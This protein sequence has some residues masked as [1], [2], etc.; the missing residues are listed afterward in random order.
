MNQRTPMRKPR[1][2]TVAPEASNFLPLHYAR[3]STESECVTCGHEPV[4]RRDD[5][6][7]QA[8]A[9]PPVINEILGSPGRPREPHLGHDFSRVRVQSDASAAASA[10]A[11]NATAYAVGGDVVFPS[12][13]CASATPEGEQPVAHEL[14]YSIPQWSAG[15]GVHTSSVGGHTAT[16]AAEREAEAAASHVIASAEPRM[17]REL[18]EPLA[19]ARANRFRSLQRAEDPAGEPGARTGSP[20]SAERKGVVMVGEPLTRATV[21]RPSPVTRSS[22]TVATGRRATSPLVPPGRGAVLP[23][24]TRADF[25]AR[26]GHNFEDVRVYADDRAARLAATQGANAFTVGSDIVFGTGQFAPHK[27]AGRNLLAHELTHVVQYEVA[28]AAGRTLSGRSRPGQAAEHQAESAAALAHGG[29]LN[30]LSFQPA[31]AEVH[32]QDVVAP[33]E[34]AASF[35]PDEMELAAQLDVLDAAIRAGRVMAVRDEVKLTWKRAE[36][37]GLLAKLN[38]VRKAETA[39]AAAPVQPIAGI[40]DSAPAALREYL[41]LDAGGSAGNKVGRD[42]AIGAITP[43]SVSASGAQAANAIVQLRRLDDVLRRALVA[44]TVATATGASFADVLT[45]YRIEGD[46]AI[47]PSQASVAGGLPPGRTDATTSLSVRPDVSNLVLLYDAADPSIS[48]MSDPALREFSLRVWFVQLGGL[49]QVGKLP[50]PRADNFAAWSHANW[51]AAGKSDTLVTARARW[52]AA[53]ALIKLERPTSA[54]GTPA[55]AAHVTDPE[56]F[57]AAIL[58]EAVI[59]QERLRRAESLLGP[60]PSGD[61]RAGTQLSAGMGYLLYNAGEDQARAVILSA[62]VFGY[63]QSGSSLSKRI[64]GDVPLKGLVSPLV[65]T[66]GKMAKA[67]VIAAAAAGWPVVD[68]WLTRAGNLELVSLFIETAGPAVWPSWQEIRANVS[69][70]RVL[71]AYYASL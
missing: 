4:S 47:P 65:A 27:D 10:Q 14:A 37:A 55:V 41:M 25:E 20:C 48:S 6:V 46:M 1:S 44:Q 49:D 17:A 38:K 13:R 16:R 62:L 53:L 52:A 69:R 32:A 15:H 36:S 24:G 43:S 12:G 30:T 11:V 22:L 7:D 3:H 8:F 63:K 70:Y 64:E 35:L 2:P 26:F 19:S 57:A 28:R 45:L 68:A 34:P 66:M 23:E 42:L 31:V 58:Q 9:V 18:A 29:S 50:A 40:P 67:N 60:L 71:Q 5:V 21:G 51:T 61:P 33:P 59:L 39:M 56:A 54:A